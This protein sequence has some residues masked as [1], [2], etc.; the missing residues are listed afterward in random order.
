MFI[1]DADFFLN[2]SKIKL[3]VIY[4]LQVFNDVD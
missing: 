4:S 1:I 2:T 3:K